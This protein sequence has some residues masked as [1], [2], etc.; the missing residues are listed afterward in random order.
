[1]KTANQMLAIFNRYSLLIAILTGIGMP[2]LATSKIHHDLPG[3]VKYL[4]N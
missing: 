3:L 1:M 4:G 2:M